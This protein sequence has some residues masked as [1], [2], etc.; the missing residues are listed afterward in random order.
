VSELLTV[1]RQVITSGLTASTTVLGNFAEG[2]P[3]TP[4]Q[5]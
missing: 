3:P 5:D 1:A 2:R 4:T